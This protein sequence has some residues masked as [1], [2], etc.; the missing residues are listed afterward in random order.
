MIY[1]YYEGNNCL[2]SLIADLKTGIGKCHTLKIVAMGCIEWNRIPDSHSNRHWAN[3]NFVMLQQ[4]CNPKRL[5]Q[6][7]YAHI[8]RMP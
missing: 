8:L 3:Y 5:I 7:I 1:R 6:L 4:S 2:K